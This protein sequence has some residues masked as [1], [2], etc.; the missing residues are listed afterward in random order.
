M[1]Y[2][3]AVKPVTV[4]G[5]AMDISARME[6][7]E[8]LS[9]SEASYYLPAE[10]SGFEL[11]LFSPEGIVKYFNS[12]ALADLGGRAED[13]EGKN[14]SDIFGIEKGSIELKRFKG[15]VETGSGKDYEDEVHLP[16][17]DRFF[18]SNVS[19]VFDSAGNVT[20]IQVLSHDISERKKNGSKAALFEEDAGATEQTHERNQR[21]RKITTGT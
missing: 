15:A 6:A 17:G 21:K 13:F 5:F 1:K 20:G 4:T 3:E 16:S 19:C 12:K 8:R 2:Y 18:L 14:V 11:G 7:Q 9:K 10:Q